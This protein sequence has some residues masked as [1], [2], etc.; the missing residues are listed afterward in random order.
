M[1]G[2]KKLKIDFCVETTAHLLL[3][4]GTWGSVLFPAEIPLLWRNYL[5]KCEVSLSDLFILVCLFFFFWKCRQ[6][7]SGKEWNNQKAHSGVET[8]EGPEP[9]RERWL[10]F[11]IP[12]IRVFH[13]S[14]IF[15]EVVNIF[16]CT[17][18]FWSWIF[19][20]SFHVLSTLFVI[21]LQIPLQ[22]P[23]WVTFSV[24]SWWF[25]SKFIK[26]ISKGKK[27]E[28][29]LSVF[30]ENSQTVGPRGA[31]W[32]FIGRTKIDL[33]SKVLPSPLWAAQSL[34]QP[35]CEGSPALH[36]KFGNSWLL[37]LS[38]DTKLG[39]Q[40]GGEVSPGT[41]LLSR[42]TWR[43]CSSPAAQNSL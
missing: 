24:E 29:L 17:K 26:T 20:P 16:W 21:E 41:N 1:I 30:S 4:K 42:N 10:G 38:P 28:H 11:L 2:S 7:V 37:L 13:D 5:E 14:S 31:L 35:E 32:L 9:P 39:A 22:C 40:G 6:S 12:H 25:F 3:V 34:W 36:W 19:D 33:I 18:A 8:A 27:K 23:A 15:H 43:G